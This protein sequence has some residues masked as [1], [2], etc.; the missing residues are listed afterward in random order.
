MNQKVLTIAEASK[1]LRVSVRTLYRYMDAGQVRGTMLGG[2]WRFYRQDLE[3]LFKKPETERVE[4][5]LRE[6]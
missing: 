4:V 3:R 6:S 5:E 1:F 2:R